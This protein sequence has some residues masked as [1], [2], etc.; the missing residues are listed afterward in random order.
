MSRRNQVDPLQVVVW[1]TKDH[2]TMEQ[3][4]RLIGK[5][6]QRVCQVLKQAGITASQGTWVSRA[7]GF[8]GVEIKVRRVLARKNTESFCH[9]EHYYASRENPSYRPWK[10]GQRLARAIVSQHFT[11][12]PGHVVHHKDS[13]NHN[14]NRENLMVFAS[15]AEHI[16]HHHGKSAVVP[17]WDGV[18]P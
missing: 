15:N 8:C 1:Y 5:T 6:R 13:D 4:G 18:A 9:A 17:L 10:Q 11:L 2:L 14:N 12:L 16:A 7:C 3:I